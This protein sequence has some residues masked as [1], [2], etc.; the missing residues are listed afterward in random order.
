MF[1]HIGHRTFAIIFYAV[2]VFKVSNCIRNGLSYPHIRHLQLVFRSKC[3][4]SINREKML[5]GTM[6]L[7]SFLIISLINLTF[8]PH[9]FL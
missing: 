4:L 3:H 1:Y 8:A 2:N 9:F 7:A 6:S 5:V